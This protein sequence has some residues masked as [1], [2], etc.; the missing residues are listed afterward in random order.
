MHRSKKSMAKCLM[1]YQNPEATEREVME[2]IQQYRGLEVKEEMFV[3]NDGSRMELINLQGT[4]PIKYRGTVYNIPLCI[5]LMDTHPN[6]PPVCYLKPTKNMRIKISM[7]VDHNGKIYMPYLHDWSPTTS[8]LMSLIQVLIMQFSDDPPLYQ[9]Q[10]PPAS[11]PYPK[12]PYMPVPVGGGATGAGGTPYPPYGTQPPYPVPQPHGMDY[13]PYTT[14]YLPYPKTTTNVTPYPI[15]PTPST[16][17]EP[18]NTGTITEQHIHASLLSAAEDKVKRRLREQL[19]QT[20]AELE[21]LDRIQQELFQGKNKLDHLMSKLESELNE[22]EKNLT[23]LRDKEHELEV[24]LGKLSDQGA[25]DVDEAVTTT[26]PLY[27]QLLTS[28]AEEAATED[29]IYYFGEALR[30]GVIDLDVFLRNVRSLSRKQF[31]LRALMQKCR[32]KAGLAG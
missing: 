14:P 16:S 19:S 1:K 20:Q 32:A 4:I 3:F 23:I 26:A 6:N 10:L 27:N 2:V 9:V 22:W 13:Q 31:M 8:D 24:S 29:V 28:F 15:Y 7:H 5:W 11:T 30:R 17:S 12:Q 18:T 21:T 25:I